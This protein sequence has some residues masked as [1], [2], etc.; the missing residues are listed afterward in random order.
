MVVGA[1]ADIS[2]NRVLVENRSVE[3]IVVID[4]DV[5][6]LLV[7]IVFVNKILE[8]EISIPEVSLQTTDSKTGK[9]IRESYQANLVNIQI[10][11]A[12]DKQIRFKNLRYIVVA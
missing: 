1:A 9:D 7:K 11:I 8:E 3:V 2:I 6:G 5:G 4:K 10:Y 12:S